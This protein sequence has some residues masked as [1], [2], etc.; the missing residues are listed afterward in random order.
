MSTQ[1]H[2]TL[3]LLHKIFQLVQYV[4]KSWYPVAKKAYFSEVH[5]NKRTDSSKLI[6]S[7]KIAGYLVRSLT[8]NT[9][10][11][12][13]FRDF[14]RLVA[15]CPLL[16]ELNLYHTYFRW[17]WLDSSIVPMQI[18]ALSIID[19]SYVNSQRYFCF[20]AQPLLSFDRYYMYPK[21]HS[22]NTAV[23]I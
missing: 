16:L 23:I 8:I 1:Y 3:E 4:C 2:F 15:Y 7:L 13:T 11:I 5:L 6:S 14:S 18:K 21:L 10:N 17:I 9:D 12:L 19:N 22:P 20:V